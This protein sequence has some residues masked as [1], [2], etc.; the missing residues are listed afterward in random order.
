MKEKGKNVLR[1]M[2][3]LLLTT[4]R[5]V[6][7]W[8][9]MLLPLA[10]LL[11]L[12]ARKIPGLAD[13]YNHTVYRGVS[14][15]WNQVTG[16]VPVSIAELLLMVLPFAVLGYLI[17]VIVRVIKSKH[18]RLK[19]AGKGL[20][21]LVSL[22]CAVYFLYVTNCGMNYY[23]SSF[24]E[25][26]GLEVKP[27][28]AGELYEVCVYLG[29]KASECRSRLEQNEEG[30]MV[31]DKADARRAAAEAMN[32]L[33][34]QYGFFPDGYSIPKPL[35]LSRGMSYLNLTGVYFPFTFES[36]VNVDSPDCF[37]PF[38]MCHELAHVRGYMKE[39]DANFIAYL[40]CIYSDN[41]AFMYS[42]YLSALHYAS[43]SLFGADR[44]LYRQYASCL[45]DEVWTDLSDDYHYW[46][47][48]QTPVAEA[49]SA[50]NDNYLKNNHQDSGV[51]SY[52]LMTDLVIA[53][54]Y[55]EKSAEMQKNY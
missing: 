7:F 2:R 3:K 34:R 22:A 35:I 4:I 6:W 44:E 24:A 17:F 27:T 31:L 42:G 16:V 15:F 10:M 8:L 19:T 13:L 52:G 41:D 23:C 49:A 38:T 11:R 51:K 1:C 47:Q 5:S 28:S 26:S 36:N 40:A 39:Q 32:R 50:I 9:I 48:F 20:L 30:V 54:Y 53:H 43:S 29:T 18:R 21:R 33:H 25:Q 46:Q 45:S 14:I 55:S 12:C 37:I